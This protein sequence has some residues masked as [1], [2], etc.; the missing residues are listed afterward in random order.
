MKQH[1]QEGK[2]YKRILPVVI[3]LLILAACTSNSPTNQPAA[4][5]DNV[6]ISV[7]DKLSSENSEI[8]PTSLGSVTVKKDSGRIVSGIMP[9]DKELVLEAADAS[10]AQWSQ[11]IPA[12][13]IPA[14]T[15]ISI[16][17]LS[18]IKNGSYPCSVTGGVMLE[19]DGLKFDKPGT[20]TVKPSSNT[21]PAI[22]L[23]GDGEGNGLN[24]LESQQNDGSIT[25]AIEHFST[26]YFQPENDPHM[27]DLQDKTTKDYENVLQLVKELLKRHIEVLPPPDI[28]L[29]CLS[30]EKY[31]QASEFADK[32]LQPEML[33]FDE[34]TKLGKEMTLLG[35]EQA[36]KES[37][38]YAG[39]IAARLARKADKLI[40]LTKD[41]N[42]NK[43]L[44]T[45]K[46][47]LRC[48]QRACAFNVNVPDPGEAMGPYAKK[49]ADYCLAELRDKHN[50]KYTRAA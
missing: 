33:Y 39:R 37:L 43:F 25:A 19:P 40:A 15:E 13:A 26:A 12:Y 50:F 31:A 30:D 17:P 49:T 18:E 27:R 4:Q 47:V 8:T 16:A 32:T 23:T 41:M 42:P 38:E 3:I 34:L 48:Y 28:S 21:S 44:A 46:A 35:S 11:T 24:F 36:E 7:V 9:A 14:G 29:E 6:E 45:V 1:V 20:L 2:M 10:G 5:N 22:M